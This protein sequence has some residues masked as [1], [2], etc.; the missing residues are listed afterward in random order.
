[1]LEIQASYAAIN[2]SHSGTPILSALAVVAVVDAGVVVLAAVLA[3][4]VVALLELV[5]D[6]AQPTKTMAHTTQRNKESLV[7]IFC[8]LRVQPVIAAEFVAGMVERENNT[9]DIGEKAV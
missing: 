7:N 4:P 2:S 3:L 9:R 1:L 5:S 6:L 8:S